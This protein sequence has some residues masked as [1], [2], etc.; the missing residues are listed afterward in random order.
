M[1]K[2]PPLPEKPIRKVAGDDDTWFLT[3]EELHQG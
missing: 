1:N 2:L 3:S